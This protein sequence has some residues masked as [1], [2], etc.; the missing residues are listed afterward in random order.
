MAKALCLGL[1]LTLSGVGSVL[2]QSGN[3]TAAPDPSRLLRGRNITATGATVPNPGMPQ[4]SGPT[5]LDL[6]IQRRDD[7][8]MNIC[9]N[10]D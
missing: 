3:N 2:A 1:V 10:C 9:T 8:E 6:N 7:K 5:Q 4:G